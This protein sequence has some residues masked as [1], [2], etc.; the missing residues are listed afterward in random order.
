MAIS[1][2]IFDL[3]GVVLD[4]PLPI[5]RAYEESHGLPSD[6]ILTV[7]GRSQK[8]ANGPV[9]R[10]WD[11]ELSLDEFCRVLDEEFAALGHRLST[12]EVLLEMAR[13]MHE[14]P[15]VMNAVAQLRKHGIATAALSNRWLSDQ[16]VD[17]EDEVRRRAFDVYLLSC[18]AKLHKPDNKFLR[19]ACEQLGV[20][21]ASVVYL[22]EI[23]ANL[24]PAAKMGMTTI[25]VS[26]PDDA[27]AE[28]ETIT[29][30]TLR[31]LPAGQEQ[32]PGQGAAQ[33]QEPGQDLERGS[34]DA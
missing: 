10:L 28:L 20:E 21:P 14:R 1:A 27:L 4:S 29:G 26:A 34:Q 22:D 11:G 2:V 19:M 8:R 18:E 7:V 3:G 32:D 9:P 6:F 25:R 30:I 17:E 5:L 23:G 15:T 13:Q 16:Q 33:A 12:A 24:K 31:N